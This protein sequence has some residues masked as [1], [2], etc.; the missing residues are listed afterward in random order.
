MSEWFIVRVKT[1]KNQFIWTHMNLCYYIVT[2]DG[3]AW[4]MMHSSHTFRLFYFQK[5]EQTFGQI[6]NTIAMGID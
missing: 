4:L 1:S 3:R 5:K 6:P 2:V